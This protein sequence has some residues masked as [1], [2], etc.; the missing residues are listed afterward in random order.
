M[1]NIPA[2]FPTTHFRSRAES[3]THSKSRKVFFRE[4]AKQDD[5]ET[6]HSS[7]T[8]DESRTTASETSIAR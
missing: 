7:E 5:S 4:T 6:L 8:V 1:K 2:S 3:C